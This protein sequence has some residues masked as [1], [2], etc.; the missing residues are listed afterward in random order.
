[1]RLVRRQFLQVAAGAVALPAISR[2][3]RAQIYPTRTV[4]MIVPNPAGGGT[5]APARIV[6]EHM[7]HTLGPTKLIPVPKSEM[8][9]SLPVARR[10][11][12]SEVRSGPKADLIPTP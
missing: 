6:G 11:A 1:M 5:D 9:P 7:S 4:T 3:A 2:I 10:L 8:G 12:E